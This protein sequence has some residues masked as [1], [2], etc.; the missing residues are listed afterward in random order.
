MKTLVI[1]DSAFGNTKMMAEAIAKG[2]GADIAHVSKVGGLKDYELMIVGSPIQGWR[3]LPAMSG[4]LSSLESGALTG[5]K[6]ATFDTR[7]KLFIHGDAM[8]K[9]AADLEKAGATIAGSSCFYVG[10]Q[11]GPLLDGEIERAVE[12]ARGLS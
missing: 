7:V 3:P 1:Y 6:A 4:F 2:I 12:W 11:Q 9:M 5:M 8:K 10:G